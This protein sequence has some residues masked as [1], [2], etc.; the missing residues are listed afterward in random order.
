VFTPYIIDAM[1]IQM[2]FN[3]N[4]LEFWQVMMGMRRESAVAHEARAEE[5][6]PPEDGRESLRKMVWRNAQRRHPSKVV[7]RPTQGVFDKLEIPL[8]F[9]GKTF[10]E[11][12][13]YLLNRHGTIAIGLYRSPHSAY[14]FSPSLEQ[15]SFKHLP[16]KLCGNLTS[17]VGDRLND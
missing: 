6:K 16:F 1:T 12:F 15:E 8:G 13:S 3:P 17:S 5:K 11:L 14:H 2:L 4:I 10:H 7:G 9:E